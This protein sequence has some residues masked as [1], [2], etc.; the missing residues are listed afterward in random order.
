MDQY[1]AVFIEV[2]ESKSFTRAAQKLHMT[3]PAVSQ[4]IKSLEQKIGTK[5]IERNNKQ[6]H[7]NKA[8]EIVYVIGKKIIANYEQMGA[9]VSELE[10]EPSGN[11][12]IGASYTIG[13]YLLPK[14]VKN[15]SKQFP[16]ITPHILIGNTKEIGEML[17]NHEIDVGLIEGNFKDEKM[18][19]LLFTTDEM[20]IIASGR[21]NLHIKG[22]IAPEELS[23][24]TWLIREE[25]SGTRKITE[26]FL[27]KNNINPKQILI[28]GSTQIIKEAV[29]AGLGISLV[30]KW[31]I[32]KE[33]KLGTVKQLPVMQ[34]PVQRDFSIIKIRQEFE[35]KAMKTF[36]DMVINHPYANK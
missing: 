24:M 22:L 29:E 31:A 28:F 34:T 26:H 12:K 33:L 15:L 1:L 9:L 2:V 18:N 30:S 5:L 21:K 3:Q 14:I 36:V 11:L 32:K 20:Y 17:L 6:L 23:D 25:G 35:T 10:N 13:E 16:Q 7:V 27:R 4:S 19:H 8:G